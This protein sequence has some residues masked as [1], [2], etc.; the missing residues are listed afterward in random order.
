MIKVKRD[1]TADLFNEV[2]S[3]V[4]NNGHYK[5]ARDIIEY[6]T[7]Y[8]P[9]IEL[10]NYEFDFNAVVNFGT[11]EGVYI[12]VFLSGNYLESDNNPRKIYD[13]GTFLTL[14]SDLEAMQIMGELCGSLT[15]YASK[16]INENI[17]RYTPT[18]EFE[19]E[20]RKKNASD[21]RNQ[22]ISS[23]S[24]IKAKDE[25]C[26]ECKICYYN[27]CHGKQYGCNAGINRFIMKEVDS[28]LNRFDSDNNYFCILD[29]SY[30]KNCD[31]F[32]HYVTILTGHD[33]CD[34]D[35]YKSIAYVYIWLCTRKQDFEHLKL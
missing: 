27:L 2:L 25:D 10:S 1:T 34:L 16:Y 13:I 8:K 12:N 30:N 23:L 4:K 22:Y 24:K 29:N 35:I 26:G 21:A 18:K 28:Y 14:R 32:S 20:I 7:S 3:L 9:P 5:K 17:D 11:N 15:Y 19:L 33:Y 6:E 31:T